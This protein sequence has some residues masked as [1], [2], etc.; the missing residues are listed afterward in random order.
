[1]EMTYVQGHPPLVIL[2]A[3]IYHI[4]REFQGPLG[5]ASE[6]FRGSREVLGGLREPCQGVP[7]AFRR[8]SGAFQEQFRENQGFYDVSRGSL[9]PGGLWGASGEFFV[10]LGAFQEFPGG[11]RQ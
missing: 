9:S 7:E 6:D 2:H 4:L 1:M 11:F 10:V 8:V 3:Q 5:R